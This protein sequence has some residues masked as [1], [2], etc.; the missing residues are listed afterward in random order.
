MRLPINLKMILLGIA[1][2]AVSFFVS[3]KAMD[4]LAPRGNVR[5]PVLVELPPL[6]PA[7][8]AS[9]II[10]PVAIALSAIRDAADRSAPRTFAGK[11]DN[12]VS[13]IL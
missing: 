13:Q 2:L 9:S 4:W 7:P 6:P 12:P 5:A 3:L 8:R 1:A 10:A 11:A